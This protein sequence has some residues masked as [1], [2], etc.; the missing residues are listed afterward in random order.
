MS[1]G[2]HFSNSKGAAT[3]AHAPASRDGSS[4]EIDARRGGSDSSA[5]ASYSERQSAPN[6]TDPFSPDY[7]DPALSPRQRRRAEKKRAQQADTD[8]GGG[9]G[10]TLLYVLAALVITVLVWFLLGGGV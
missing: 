1:G 5:T 3:Y 2:K 10:W 7:Q 6:T 8:S 9:R 4:R